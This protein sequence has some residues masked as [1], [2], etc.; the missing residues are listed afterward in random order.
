MKTWHACPGKTYLVVAALALGTLCGSK[1]IIGAAAPPGTPYFSHDGQVNIV[2]SSHQDTAWMD[3]PAFCR[4][5]RIHGVLLPALEMMRKDP[6]Y[7]FC[8]EGALHVMELLEAHPELRDEVIG[9]MKE[10][11]LE[12]GATYNEPYESWM[13]GEE[14]VRETYFGRRWIKTSLPGCDAK[15]A[16][17][18]DPPGR[19]L[20]MQQI[21]AKAG[22]PYMF[23]SRY[24][25][26][27]YRWLSPDGT[28]P[29]VYSPGH[30]GN[31][32]AFLVGAP[33]DCSAAIWR[34]LAHEDGYYSQRAIPPAYCLINS[35]D[36]S[37]PINFN[38]L[39][40]FWNAQSA[41][42]AAK[43]PMMG[44]SSIRGFFESIDKPAAKF[45]TVQGERPDVW[46]YITGPTHHYTASVK[47]E[48]AR[49]LPAAETFTTIACLLQGSFNDWPGKALD[50]AWKDEIYIDHGIGGK[51]GHITD[52]VFH[53]RTVNARDT[54]RN[55]LDKALE[56]I[57]AQVKVDAAK[58][59][60]VT[61][62]NDLSWARSD[63]VEM[64]IPEALAGPV[65][66][67][68][69]DGKEVPSQMTLL[70]QAEEIN[71]AAAAMGAKATASSIFNPAYA[72]EKAIDGHWAV[73]DPNPE[74]GNSDKWN[75]ANGAKGPH[76]L[77]ID[78]GQA[79]TIHKVVVR[80]EGVIGAFGAETSENTSDFQIQGAATANGPWSDL[81][82]PI[83]GNTLPL[84]AHNFPPRTVKFIRLLITKGTP[85][86]NSYARIYEVQAFAQQP[87]KAR[88]LLF[89]A[90][91]V[92]AL[93]YKTYYLA[94]GAPAAAAVD[95]ATENKFYRLELAP[96]GIKSIFDKTQNH[97]MLNT[98][99]FLGGEVFTML[100]VAPNNRGRGTDA[101][102]FGTVPLPVMDASFDRVA[103][104]KPQWKMVENGTLRSVH[105]LHQPLADTTVVQRV[106]LWH[107][108]KRI[109]CEVELQ[110]FNGRLWREYRMALPLAAA[111]AFDAPKLAYEVPMGVL[112][113]GKDEIPTTGGHAYG[114][115][116]YPQQCR[117]IHPRLM[118]NFVDASDATGGL[119]MSSS[120]SA[121]D[122]VDPT[123]APVVYP[124]LQP[125]LLASRKSCNGEGNWYP[126]AGDHH[127]RFSLTG[128]A[129]SWHSSWHDGIG[130][131]HPLLPV[132]GGPH[133]ALAT[134]PDQ[135]SFVTLSSANVLIST[136]KKCEDDDS[137]VVRCYDIEGKD[138]PL[139][140]TLPGV[141]VARAA[142]TNMIEEETT[143]LPLEA[144]AVTFKVGH[145]AIETMKLVVRGKQD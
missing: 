34:K 81:V 112:E 67:V 118:Q 46:L 40:N 108:M 134:L 30:Y 57:A 51:N 139:H 18:P 128:H 52:E 90:C 56:S 66:V 39:I 121:F 72:A 143:P 14:L 79:R 124:V 77:T 44:Y 71:V 145:H 55:L 38:P 53:R 75:T 136:I 83:T 126:Q 132:V 82:S 65:H 15:V 19:A 135:H 32:L 54:G 31:H 102:E 61:V 29:L 36:F 1:R 91:D 2:S 50:Q 88:T 23:I 60:P 94:E 101:G 140:L 70:G 125:I 43:P 123:A 122:W 106:I 10:G 6:H 76:W 109:D 33:Q 113:I 97:D 69:A 9:R 92:P 142:A 12:F 59:T 103:D 120:V 137:V 37:R 17:N 68:D 13:S 105:E 96:G 107:S 16:F 24:H 130:A 117:D 100:S 3:T 129:G 45:D 73:R 62:F 116:T 89:A 8:M 80:H 58:G 104:H 144:G 133:A 25:E 7:T 127:F 87:A 5:F 48:A 26:G 84:T 41:T 74:T 4:N 47:R 28:G 22:I 119:M 95:N 138:S 63:V 141:T 131:N 64:T 86:D 20:Q 93:G 115:L 114:N 49:L 98:D 11:R 111:D 21:L 27:L 85:G 78:F 42:G 35:M 99:K 110:D